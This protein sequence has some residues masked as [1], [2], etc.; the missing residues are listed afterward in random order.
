VANVL[1]C[2]LGS[3]RGHLEAAYQHLPTI[4]VKHVE[5]GL[6]AADD[7]PALMAKLASHGLSPTTVIASADIAGDAYP[8]QWADICERATQLG[9]KVVF[10]SVLAGDNPREAVYA[11]LRA[12]GDVAARHGIRI[13]METHPDLM[14]NGTVAT[15]T[16]QAVA[17]PNIGMNFDCANI[18]YYNEGTT[19]V[20]QLEKIAPRVF[21]VHLKDSAGLYKTW[22]FPTLGQGIVD[23]PR[24]FEILNGAGFYG[25]FTMELEGIEGQRLNAEEACADVAASV[26]YL[27][28]IAEFD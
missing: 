7:I 28:S 11:R 19:T 25:P 16:L 23:F 22:N 24:V 8:D 26:E 3:Y 15:E 2:N 20:A 6:P 14:T 17:H 10:T 4:G 21:S 9:V 12:A 1:S 27:R 13:A 5:F 18:M